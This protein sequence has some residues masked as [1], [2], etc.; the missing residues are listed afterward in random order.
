MK[1]ISTFEGFLNESYTGPESVVFDK[2]RY[3]SI[4]ESS[5]FIKL[6]K[7]LYVLNFGSVMF[8]SD[9]SK[10]IWKKMKKELNSKKFDTDLEFSTDFSKRSI[11]LNGQYDVKIAANKRVE[12]IQKSKGVILSMFLPEYVL[13]Q[14]NITFHDDHPD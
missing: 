3:D 1:H 11:I 8:M 7:E 4:T 9:S 12:L 5:F 2:V 13:K 14:G 6:A 10:A